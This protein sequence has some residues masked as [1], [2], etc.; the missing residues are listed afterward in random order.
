M[1][2]VANATIARFLST[3]QFQLPHLTLEFSFEG[4]LIA[5]LLAH[6]ERKYLILVGMYVRVLSEGNV[7]SNKFCN[8][9][10]PQKP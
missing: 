6:Y 9:H 1:Y 5:R 10:S 3:T 8:S 2:W 7:L 4:E